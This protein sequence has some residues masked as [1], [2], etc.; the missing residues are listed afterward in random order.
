MYEQQL[1]GP[2]DSNRRVNSERS[3]TQR[4]VRLSSEPRIHTL[5][6]IPMLTMGQHFYLLTILKNPKAY[7]TLN[8]IWVRRRPVQND[9]QIANRIGIQPLGLHTLRRRRVSQTWD[10]GARRRAD[11]ADPS[12][13]QVD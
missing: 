10:G 12:R 4:T 8:F 6:M 7:R 2:A 11:S 13:V 9:R 5:G 3:S 1:P